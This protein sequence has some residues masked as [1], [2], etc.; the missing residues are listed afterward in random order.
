MH[1]IRFLL[2]ASAALLICTSAIAVPRAD[3]LQ[4]FEGRTESSGVVRIIMKKPYRTRS[5]GL[6]RIERDGSL[7]LVQRVED[8][9]RPPRERKWKIR[10]IGPNRYSGTM[11]EAVGPVSIDEVAGRYRFRFQMKGHLSVEQ[12]MAPQ[13]GGMA[14]RNSMTVRK[15][16]MTVGTSDGIIHKFA[17]R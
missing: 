16:G 17:S 10:K 12:W 11:S 9:G 5:V 6:G 3:P 2:P 15:F 4:F 8:E 14:A 13:P 7:S 1:A